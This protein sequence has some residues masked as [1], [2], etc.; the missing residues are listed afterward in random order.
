MSNVSMTADRKIIDMPS[1]DD[2]FVVEI[3]KDLVSQGYNGDEL[4]AKFI[5]QRE[6]FR[7]A[8]GL[9][10]EQADEIAEGKRCSAATEDIF[11]GLADV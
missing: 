4:V 7:R 5:E 3:L 9:L 11:G 1:N 2:S 10:I 8:I 6:N